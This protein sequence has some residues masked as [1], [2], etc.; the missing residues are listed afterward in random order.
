MV[1]FTIANGIIYI[2]G[3]IVYYIME[4]Y[5]GPHRTLVLFIGLVILFVIVVYVFSSG[6]D[7]NSVTLYQG[8]VPSVFCPTVRTTK[9]LLEPLSTSGD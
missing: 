5:L 8:E 1:E 2:I 7:K 6:E 4:L 3:L 9:S